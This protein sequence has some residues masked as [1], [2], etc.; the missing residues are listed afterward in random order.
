MLRLMGANGTV[1]VIQDQVGTPTA[2]RSVAE[3]IWRIV[4]NPAIH[5]LHHWTDAGVASWYDFAV[6]IAEEAAQ[7]GLLS[8]EVTVMPIATEEYPTRARRP[9]YSVLDK[10]SL[11]SLGMLPE[12]WRKRLRKVLEEVKNA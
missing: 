4:E 8:P 11:T 3:I 6:A 9:A 1:R 5:G 2:A 7:L 12:H 10:R